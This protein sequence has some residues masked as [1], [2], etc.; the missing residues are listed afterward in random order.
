MCRLQY[1]FG[2]VEFGYVIKAMLI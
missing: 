1:I 2:N